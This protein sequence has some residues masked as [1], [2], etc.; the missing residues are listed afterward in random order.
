M[1]KGI[2]TR[3]LNY[4]L[5]NPKFEK[6]I[7]RALRR[8]FNRPELT[9]GEK[10]DIVEKDK[11]KFNEWLM[12]D[13]RLK[14]K[15]TL[16]QDFCQ[17]NPYNLSPFKLQAYKD[18][19]DN[20][21]GVFEVLEVK[22]G[23]GLKLKNLRTEKEYWI[24]EYSATFQIKEKGLLVV[25]IVRT[26]DHLELAGGD[27]Y[28]LPKE[29]KTFLGRLVV[30]P[31]LNSKKA[32]DYFEQ[33]EKVRNADYSSLT[34]KLLDKGRCI[35]D[36]CGK[37]GKMAATTYDKD[38]GEPIVICYKCNLERIAEEDGISV[39]EAEKKRKRMF[40]VGY[41]FQNIKMK[42]YLDFKNKEEMGSVKEMN[43]VLKRIIEA[44]NDLSIKQRKDFEIM[45]NKELVKV[46]KEIPVDFSNL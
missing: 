40:E 32:R 30:D 11:G 20:E 24:R 26:G 7:L 34:K 36:I 33:M 25:R 28:G 15:K 14:N 29:M 1:E 42:E 16:L 21:Y 27:V 17:R 3:L 12:F 10:F 43:K 45:K 23:E 39:K 35:C 8:F 41:L 38:T 4:Y 6:E 13:F 37:K 22:I 9:F 19:Q 5:G 46:Y 31:R 2:I 18:L 44:W